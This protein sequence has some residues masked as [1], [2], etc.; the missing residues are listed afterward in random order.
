MT[1]H[2]EYFQNKTSKRPVLLHHCSPILGRIE[3]KKKQRKK[4]GPFVCL[5]IFDLC[6]FI[7]YQIVDHVIRSTWT[8]IC[9]DEFDG[10]MVTKPVTMSL[11][12]VHLAFQHITQR[13]NDFITIV[14]LLKPSLENVKTFIEEPTENY[15][16]STEEMV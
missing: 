10:D 12:A 7:Y 16:K 8:E 11:P 13:L 15:L 3:N 14:R 2:R 6:F 1:I 4:L 5:P 9:L